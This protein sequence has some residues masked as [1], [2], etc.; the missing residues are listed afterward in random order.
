MGETTTKGFVRYTAGLFV[1]YASA[2]KV[3][4]EIVNAGYKDAFIVAFYN[5]KRIPIN[6]AY[7][8]DMGIPSTVLQASTKPET[9]VKSVTPNVVQNRT[10]TNNG[11]NEIVTPPSVS[12]IGGLFYTV[13][14]GVF[15]KKVSRG[16]LF[17][18]DPLYTETAP[19]GN[20]LYYT[21]AYKSVV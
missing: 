3:K 5:G 19:N 16:K 2:D 18:M 6:Q 4:K 8:M 17:N 13:Q 12:A 11:Q 20:F 14:V 7:A 9:A 10:P 21:G 1:K 15:S